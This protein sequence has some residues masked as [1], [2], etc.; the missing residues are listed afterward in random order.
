MREKRE[1]TQL[2]EEIC[3]IC[4]G[5]VE[6]ADVRKGKQDLKRRLAGQSVVELERIKKL[7]KDNPNYIPK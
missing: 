1:S 3:D 6:R 7:V 4:Y 2:I 5:P